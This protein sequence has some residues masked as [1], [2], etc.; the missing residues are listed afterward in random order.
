[1]FDESSKANC[2]VEDGLLTHTNILMDAYGEMVTFGPSLKT[3]PTKPEQY[4]YI[5]LTHHL[6][7]II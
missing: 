2:V 7:Q 6:R 5:H 4:L 3:W 1:M